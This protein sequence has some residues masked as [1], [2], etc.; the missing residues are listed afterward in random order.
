MPYIRHIVIF[1]SIL[2]LLAVVFSLFRGAQGFGAAQ[3]INFSQLLSEV[4]GGRIRDVTIAGNDISGHYAD[5]T[6]FET[7]A[8]QDPA[9]VERLYNKGVN[10]TAQPPSS[11][12]STLFG[13]PDL[14]VSNAPADRSL[15]V[16]YAPDAIGLGQGDG[17]R[18]LARAHALRKTRPHHLQRCRRSR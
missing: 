16:L 6:K 10:I 5:G 12:S 2:L 17:L 9:L 4:D 14:L 1:L 7:Y 18:A 15:G 8:P 13:I 11:G 3:E